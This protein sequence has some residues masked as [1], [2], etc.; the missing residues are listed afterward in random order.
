MGYLCP[1]VILST[2]RYPEHSPSVILSATKD[3]KAPVSDKKHFL[4]SSLC[5]K[6]LRSLPLPQ[7]DKEGSLLPQ[8][9]TGGCGTNKYNSSF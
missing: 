8:N 9:D 2:P 3:L 1:T 5:C 7:N 4:C 6:I